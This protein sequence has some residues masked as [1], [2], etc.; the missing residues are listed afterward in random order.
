VGF[1]ESGDGGDA[2]WVKTADTDTSSQTPA[3][4]GDAKFTDSDGAVWELSS[5]RFSAASIGY[6][7]GDD[8]S[9]YMSCIL[10]ANNRGKTFIFDNINHSTSG[11][12][13]LSAGFKCETMS[14]AVITPNAGFS[15][16]GV[17][18][19]SGFSS[20]ITLPRITD[21]SEGSAITLYGSNLADMKI[22]RIARCKNA[23]KLKTTS[24]TFENSKLLDSR[25]DVMFIATCEN[26][27]LW[28][29]DSHENVMQGNEVYV[30]FITQTNNA[31]IFKDTT[32]HTQQADWDSNKVQ[33]QAFDPLGLDVQRLL[34][35]ESSF[36]VPR[37]SFKVE[38]WLGGFDGVSP[39]IIEGEFNQSSI[40][41]S[42]VQQIMKEWIY[43]SGRQNNIKLKTRMDLA[44]TPITAE[45]SSNPNGFNSG[46]HLDRGE[47]LVRFT[48]VGDMAPG[49][50][51][52]YYAYHVLLGGQG[53]N[54]RGR[55]DSYI[56]IK[57]AA[58]KPYSLSFSAYSNSINVENEI[59]IR[60]TNT[61]NT[62][63]VSG[64][65][66]DVFLKVE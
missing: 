26:A 48:S 12:L 45:N 28:E 57:Q 37:L 50:T 14:E 22:N 11:P 32:P 59:I 34:V 15:G 4:L 33:I 16:D 41:L 8:F 43:F 39:K 38:S 9:E 36:G 35:N 40:E 64:T 51:T 30:N 23:I 20:A 62:T 31:C 6:Y 49:Q 18:I 25:I 60:V 13:I 7:D 10:A 65:S 58:I 27:I 17:I 53:V 52:T 2:Q 44:N 63:I 21:F 46:F 29:S 47:S 66:F 42:P 61:S 3:Q 19:E 1:Y 56:D 54:S 24:D 5:S 55:A